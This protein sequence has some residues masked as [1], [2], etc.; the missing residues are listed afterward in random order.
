MS[1]TIY[2]VDPTTRELLGNA[3]APLDPVA[4]ER[5]GKLVYAEVNSAN[6]TDQLPPK[7]D[8][9]AD[10]V[11]LNSKGGWEVK[12]GA[13][14]ERAQ[15]QIV[16][17]KEMEEKAKSEQREAMLAAMTESERKLFLLREEDADDFDADE[18]E[19]DLAE[20]EA[21]AKV[22]L[23]RHEKRRANKADKANQG[24]QG[25]QGIKKTTPAEVNKK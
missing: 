9:D 1:K 19:Q 13:K 3:E 24:N 16:A 2:I 20:R 23:E 8:K 4:S 7:H 5:A 6:A 14:A 10:D 15:A 18:K 21:R 12:R 17:A 22:R 11:V 25:N